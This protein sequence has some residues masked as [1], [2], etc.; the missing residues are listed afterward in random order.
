MTVRNGPKYAL[1]KAIKE[2]TRL[3][4]AIVSALLG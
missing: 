3:L 2:K 4:R 1:E